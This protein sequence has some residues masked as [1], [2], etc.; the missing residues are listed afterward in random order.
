MEISRR[1]E[2]I[3]GMVTRDFTVCDVGTDH[4]YL[5][6]YLVE[7]GISPK[8]IAMDVAKGPLSKA[9]ANVGAYGYED[10]IET[11]LSDGVEKL[12]QGEAQ[13][14]IMAGMGGILI[15]RLLEN[16][17]KTLESVHELILSPHTDV[18]LVRKYLL[19]NGYIIADEQMMT[20]EGKYYVMIK[21]EHGA[22]P[23]YSQC[24]YNFGKH[25]LLKQNLV[26]KEFLLKEL[27][28][29]Q[30]IKNSLDDVATE[31]ARKRKSE[32][33]EEIR[34]VKEGLGYYEM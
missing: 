27:D 11:R 28:K 12:L 33:E 25:L 24:E 9:Q 16:G 3:A 31:N 18:C 21:A 29:L 6:I 8:V 20:E 4:G 14:V 1:L 22:E 5:A 19:Q 13:T 2:T 17:R 7:Q 32:L 34:L 15:N 10:V 30:L 23:E 26:L